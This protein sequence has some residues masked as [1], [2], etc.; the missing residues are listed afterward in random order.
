MKLL[1]QNLGQFKRK[2]VMSKADRSDQVEDG[3]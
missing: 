2:L 3:I 1:L